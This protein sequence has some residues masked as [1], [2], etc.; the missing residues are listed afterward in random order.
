[1]NILT[2]T[3]L[4]L[5][6]FQSCTSSAQD[7]NEVLKKL[8]NALSVKQTSISNI[9]SDE[10]YMYQ[11]SQK[12][13]RE[14]IKKYAGTGTIKIVTEN[15]PGKRIKVI[16]TVKDNKGKPFA[17]AL[18]YFYQ[19]SAKGWYSDTAAH[20]LVNEGDHRH[21]RLFGYA[22]TNNEGKIE[23]ETIQPSG[24]PNSDLP[25]HIHISMWKNGSFVQGVPGELLFEDD[26]RLTEERKLRAL[27]E[28][29]IISKNTGTE[30]DPVYNYLIKINN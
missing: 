9:L 15:E 12:N 2:R 1:M 19:T 22:V 26:K 18:I 30:T 7:T 27:H 29:F 3:I 24:Y 5:L 25:A 16:C 8:E 23:I 11:H 17:G 28:G 14:L 20:I 13:F 21:A 10:K 6:I 4:G